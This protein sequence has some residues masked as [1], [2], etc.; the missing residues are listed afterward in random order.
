MGIGFYARQFKHR[1]ACLLELSHHLV[2]KT[3]ALDTATAIDNEHFLTETCHFLMQ[4]TQ[5]IL[6]KIYLGLVLEYKVSHIFCSFPYFMM[7]C[8]FCQLCYFSCLTVG[9]GCLGS[10]NGR[11]ILDRCP[12]TELLDETHTAAHT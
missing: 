4:V 7:F 11:T 1:H 10:V 2:V 3:D 5:L 12:R 8:L 9:I 6:A